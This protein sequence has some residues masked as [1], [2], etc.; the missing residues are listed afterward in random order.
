MPLRKLINI[1][2]LRFIIIATIFILM[3]LKYS[4]FSVFHIFIKLH[5]LKWFIFLIYC[6]RNHFNIA[7]YFRKCSII[8]A[9]NISVVE[10][11]VMPTFQIKRLII[12]SNNLNMLMKKL[13]AE[14]QYF[15]VNNHNI[16]LF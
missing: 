7:S 5:I 3:M 12:E 15:G 14:T 8:I 13:L 4:I 9:C 10:Y 16:F 6:I 1:F 11:N 2:L